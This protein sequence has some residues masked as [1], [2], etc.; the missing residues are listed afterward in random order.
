MLSAMKLTFQG[1]H[2]KAPNCSRAGASRISK[3]PG[4]IPPDPL[5]KRKGREKGE[6][7]RE[8]TVPRVY[9]NLNPG[10]DIYT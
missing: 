10:L 5:S 7:G 2:F 9:A 1:L 8:G 6:E 3:F 4:V